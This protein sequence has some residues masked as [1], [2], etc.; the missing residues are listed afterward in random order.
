MTALFA[1]PCVALVIYSALQYRAAHNALIDSFPPEWKDS[2]TEKF[3]LGEMGLSPSTPLPIQTNYMNSI[4]AGAV[5]MLL[6]SLTLF[7]LSE[8]FGGWLGMIF[9]LFG[10]VSA[11]KSW[12]VYKENCKRKAVV[13]KEEQ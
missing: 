13:N 2:L 10:V 9:F 4:W 6:F 11:I 12:R 8:S 3:V 1:I 5:A 7:S